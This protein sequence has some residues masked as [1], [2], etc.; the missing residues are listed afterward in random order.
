MNPDHLSTPFLSAQSE[1][2]L[3]QEKQ[4]KAHSS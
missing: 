3:A 4:I 2:Y 1:L